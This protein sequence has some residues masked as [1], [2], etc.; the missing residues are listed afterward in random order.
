MRACVCRVDW[1]VVHICMIVMFCALSLG[2]TTCNGTCQT[3]LPTHLATFY[4][5]QKYTFIKPTDIHYTNIPRLA[6]LW[7]Y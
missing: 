1:N 3:K 6:A 7:S 4:L 2:I 5:P